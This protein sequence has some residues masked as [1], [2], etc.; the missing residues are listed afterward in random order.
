ME[1]RI[2]LG[3][4]SSSD[5]EIEE[6]GAQ[7]NNRIGN[8]NW[9][10]CGGICKPMETYTESLCCRETNEIPKDFFK[11][12][13]LTFVFHYLLFYYKSLN[14]FSISRGKQ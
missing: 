2:E 3:E 11:G 4:I 12:E 6:Y 8:S 10:V 5:E 14:K 7:M 1:P 13:I 9:C